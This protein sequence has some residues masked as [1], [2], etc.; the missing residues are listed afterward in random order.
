VNLGTPLT[1][2]VEIGIQTKIAYQK[3]HLNLQ[4]KKNMN[5]E[6][7]GKMHVS[8]MANFVVYSSQGPFLCR[9]SGGTCDIIRSSPQLFYDRLYVYDDLTAGSLS[10]H[11]V[12]QKW[13]AMKSF[14]RKF[15][16]ILN[17]DN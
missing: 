10:R 16:V 12:H 7:V 17:C 1:F 11:H 14:L 5:K 9:H 13:N 8:Q 2:R 4:V 15:P 6:M 3:R